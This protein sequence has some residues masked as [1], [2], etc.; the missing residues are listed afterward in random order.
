M[1]TGE[2]TAFGALLR[3]YR[4]AAHLTQKQLAERVGM[5]S[6][7]IAALEHGDRRPP[8]AATVALLADALNLSD[9]ERTAFKAAVH[10]I[11]PAAGASTP[12]QAADVIR[13]NETERQHILWLPLQPTPLIGRTQEVEAIGR[14]LTV[15]GG[16]LLTL[17]GPAGVGKTRL[18]LAAAANAQLVDRFSDGVTLVDLAPIRIPQDV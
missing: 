12:P 17:V 6:R 10:S 18:A 7:S 11:G 3:R 4:A 8:P 1:S 13:P 15:D 2:P 9:A 5:S 16:R 14:L